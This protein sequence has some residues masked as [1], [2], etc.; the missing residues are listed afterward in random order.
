MWHAI[1]EWFME[2]QSTMFFFLYGEMFWVGLVIFVLAVIYV[3]IM[4]PYWWWK[5]RKFKKERGF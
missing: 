2:A 3:V 1:W 5:E 4:T